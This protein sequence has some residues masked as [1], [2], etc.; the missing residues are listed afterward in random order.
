MLVGH[1]A[2]GFAAKRAAPQLSLALLFA[3]CQLAD[4]MWPAFVA[5]GFESVRITPGITAFTP[6]EFISYPYSHSLVALCLWGIMLG[7]AC[8]LL[9]TSGRASLLIGG[10]VVSHWILDFVSHRPDMPIYPGGALWGLGLW[11]SVPATLIVELLLFGAGVWLYSSMTRAKNAVGRWSF[12]ALAAFL[13]IVYV[14]SFASGPPPS[15]A[16]VSRA[17]LVGGFVIIG[18]SWWTDRHR[19]AV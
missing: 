6:L 12:V 15:V 14:G 17:G 13:L 5:A 18:W 2:L 10:L 8:W 3:A 16:A 19:Q 7:S 1:F 4:I 11:N 9:G